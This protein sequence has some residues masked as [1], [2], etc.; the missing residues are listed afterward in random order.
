MFGVTRYQSS[1]YQFPPLEFDP[2]KKGKEWHKRYCEALYSFYVRDITSIPYS[3]REDM[4]LNRLYA[5]G[6]QPTEKY[7]EKLTIKNQKSNARK[8]WMDLSHDILSVAPKFK[9]II[10]GI[11]KKIHHDID[12]VAMDSNSGME[13][14]SKKYKAWADAKLAPFFEELGIGIETDES[15]PFIPSSLEEL[16]VIQNMGAFKLKVE[17]L[18]ERV[19]EMALEDSKWDVVKEQIYSD[20]FD[21]AVAATQD[22]IDPGSNK[23]MARWIDPINVIVQYSKHKDFSNIDKWG[24]VE[25]ITISELIREAGGQIPDDAYKEIASMYAGYAGNSAY[26]EGFNYYDYGAFATSTNQ[27]KDNVVEVIRCEWFSTDGKVSKSSKTSYGHARFEDK[28]NDYQPS[29]RSKNERVDS[30]QK[31]IYRATWIVGT[32]YVYN[33]GKQTDIPR[34][35]YYKEDPKLSLNIYK[36]GDKSM[37]ES[38]IPMLDS[39]Q[40]TWLKLQNAIAKAPPSGLSVEIGALENISIGGSKLRPLEILTLRRQTGDIIYR[41]TTHH[42]QVRSGSAAKPINDLAGGIGPQ[43]QELLQMMDVNMA[44]IRDIL[45]ISEGMAAADV[46]P[47]LAVGVQKIAA[48]STNNVL[49]NLYDGYKHIRE[50]TSKQ[51]FLRF[52]VLAI[53]GRLKYYEKSLGENWLKLLDAV[54]N[55]PL[56]TMGM[57]VHVKPNDEERAEIKQAALTSMQTASQGGIGITMRDYLTLTRYLE[58]GKLHYAE[59]YLTYREGE[60]EKKRAKETQANTELQGQTQ[61]ALEDK[62]TQNMAIQSDIQVKAENAKSTHDANEDRKTAVLQSYLDIEKLHAEL[63]GEDVSMARDHIL[64]VIQGSFPGLVPDGIQGGAGGGQQAPP[65]PQEPAQQPIQEP[66]VEQ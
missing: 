25:R 16:E 33:W 18:T 24:Y 20:L 54:K 63:N 41:A 6:N 11:F 59:S 8:G 28:D 47:R 51:F 31:M 38:I 3:K 26:D 50:Q 7:R 39:I 35:G 66:P 56:A 40:L 17:E 23:V 27:M 64:Q 52:Q 29:K 32:N 2:A 48:E 57:K 10:M 60:A 22:Y 37:L 43:L 13:R 45:G 49:Y 62:K 14:E 34:D 9:S 55:V 44:W 21:Q 4:I 53:S 61:Q 1:N 5:Q 36:M 19:T 46:N 65:V 58:R 42:S 15:L 12:V 30:K